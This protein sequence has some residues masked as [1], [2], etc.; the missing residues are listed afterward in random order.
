M[1][2]FHIHRY[3]WGKP[4]TELWTATRIHRITGQT[5]DN[6]Y[7]RTFQEGVCACGSTKVREL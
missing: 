7:T 5:Y 2:W 6:D 3:I 4:R 1:K